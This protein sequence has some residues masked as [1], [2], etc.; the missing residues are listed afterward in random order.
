MEV[1]MAAK[2]ITF[3]FPIIESIYNQTKKLRKKPYEALGSVMVDQLVGV[4]KAN[5]K[6]SAHRQ[7]KEFV[8][9]VNGIEVERWKYSNSENDQPQNS[10]FLLINQ[11]GTHIYDSMN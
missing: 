7:R 5:F 10:G 2:V 4:K 11:E 1:V 9:L 8:V 6:I 3:L